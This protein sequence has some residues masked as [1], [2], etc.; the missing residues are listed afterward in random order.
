MKSH[1]TVLGG[2]AVMA[3]ALAPACRNA[4][5]D[6]RQ[7][8]EKVGDKA[9]EVG[10]K[11]AEGVRDVGAKLKEGAK[12]AGAGIGAA[13]QTLD[14]KAAL[15]GDSSID[16]SHI[17]VSTDADTK[18]LTLKGTVPSAAQRA[19]VGK[20]AKDKAEGYKVSNRL[21]VAKR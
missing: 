7:A 6:S 1:K 21:T 5:Q 18:T 20:L 12:D 10:D 9:K 8:A 14:V 15:M 19:A 3:L 4:E 2:L 11:V 17:D 16:S 13:K